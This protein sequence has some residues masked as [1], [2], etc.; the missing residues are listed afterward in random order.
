[1]LGES[2]HQRTDGADPWNFKLSRQERR[3]YAATLGA[4]GKSRYR[5]AFEPGCAIGDFTALLA[6]LCDR[7][8]ATEVSLTAARRAVERC[9]DFPRVEIKC[10]DLRREVPRGP[11]DLVIFG[12][13]GCYFDAPTLVAIG[14]R[15]ATTLSAGGE[16]VAVHWLNRVGPALS[17]DRVHDQLREH[18]PLSWVGGQRSSDFRIDQW[19]RREDT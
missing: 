7:V 13:I 16:F 19:R 5:H 3:R 15:I 12:E 1:M 18:L 10:E 4:L 14:E 9:A 8:L 11:F 6:P 17:G 2:A